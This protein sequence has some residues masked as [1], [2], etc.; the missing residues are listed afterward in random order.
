MDH[1]VGVVD[2]STG[3][4]ASCRI[5][6][7]QPECR[8]LPGNL[9]PL[10]YFSCNHYCHPDFYQKLFCDPRTWRFILSLPHDRN[11]GKKLDGI[12]WMDG[13]WAFD[14]SGIWQKEE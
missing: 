8:F 3:I 11:S 5:C 4:Q 7:D 1:T 2:F 6:T 10:I 9:I 14:L 12:F 13:S